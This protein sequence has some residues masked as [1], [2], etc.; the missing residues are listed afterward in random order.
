M[1]YF[2][3]KSTGGFY[4]LEI[5]GANIPKDAIQITEE[6]RIALAEGEAQG[7]LIKVD[8]KGRPILV[9]RPGPTREE[10]FARIRAERNVLFNELDKAEMIATRRKDT[11][12]I[13]AIQAEKERLCNLPTTLE[14]LSDKELA[15]FTVK[16]EI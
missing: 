14:K 7:K 6:Q 2:Y 3:S 13:S 8:K 4:L 9:D 11:A 15:S 1:L 5:H 10:S 12:A 16:T